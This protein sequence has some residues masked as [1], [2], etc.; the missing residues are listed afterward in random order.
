M[1][2]RAFFILIVV[3]VCNRLQLAYAN[4]VV[5]AH[6]GASGYLPEHT[7][8]AKTA[9]FLMD[10]DYIEQDVVLT[11]DNIPIVLHDIYFDEVTNVASVFPSRSR[12]IVYEGNTVKRYYAIDFDLKEI[13][14]LRVSE[15]FHFDNNSSSIYPR[16]FPLWKSSFQISTLAEEIELVQGF[17]QSYNQIHSLYSTE[18]LGSYQNRT[19][20][21]YVEIKRPDFHKKEKKDN[22]S[23]IVL[24][25]LETYGY[26]SRKDNAIV[27]CFDPSEL[28]RIRE[29][30]G[31]DLKL[32]QLLSPD[33]S[34]KPD[35][36]GLTPMNYSFWNSKNGLVEISKFADGIGPEK[37]QL[38]EWDRET[39]KIK[40]SAMYQNAKELHLFMH[41][42]TFRIDALPPYTTS[43]HGLLEIFVDELQ[44]DGLFTD[45]PDLTSAFIK[46]D[47]KTIRFSLPIILFL[48][49]IYLSYFL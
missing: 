19:F 25:I 33:T 32:V 6:R 20:G 15:R 21:I 9:A 5:I 37:G 16:R 27:Q 3:F 2:L 29:G 43:Y 41:P 31:S 40:P 44:V 28:S 42:Y 13:K 48:L 49:S 7:L 10:S 47:S 12:S 17:E 46:N 8:E 4:T 45:F 35:L 23:E 24:D 1:N 14:Q 22:F 36:E 34:N 30:L 39:G 26:K 11:R 18:I 38:I